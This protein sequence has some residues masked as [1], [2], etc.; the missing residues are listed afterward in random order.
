[1][2]TEVTVKMEN[3][4]CLKE[5]DHRDPETM[6]EQPGVK[7]PDLSHLDLA[8]AMVEA[9]NFWCKKSKYTFKYVCPRRGEMS[10][11]LGSSAKW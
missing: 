5:N 6:Y 4:A 7:L 10:A 3:L 1:M 2:L 8:P 9:A 11:L